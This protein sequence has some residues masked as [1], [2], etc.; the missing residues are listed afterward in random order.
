MI[1][2]GDKKIGKGYPVFIIGEIGL[3][4]NG[5]IKTAKKLID[6]VKEA[7]ADCVKFQK[8]DLASIYQKKVLDDPNKSEQGFQYLIPRLK[9]FEFGMKEYKEIV[10]YCRKKGIIF[11]CTPWDISSVNFL[12]KLNVL[13]Y[14]ISSPD[15]TNLPLLDYVIS[16]RKPILIS[17]GMSTL[18]EIDKSV[19][20]LKKKKAEF[21]LFHCSSTYPAPLEAI[22][23]NFIN[24]L[25]KRY[26]VPVGYSGHERGIGVSIAVVAMGAV[27][28][29]RHITLDRKME[30][31]DHRASLEPE[32]F[33]ALVK[34]IREAEKALGEDKKIMTR[35]EIL[36]REILGKSLVAKRKIKK[37][38]VLK[39]SIIAVKGPAKGLS[40]QRISDLIGKKARRNMEK[41]DL[42]LESDLSKT[43]LSLY[44]KKYKFKRI[45][46]LKSRLTELDK[47]VNFNPKLLELHFSDKD[48]EVPFQKR[49]YD[50]YLYIH[51]P[52]YWQNQMVDLCS[53]NEKQRKISI[54][55]IKK[56]LDRARE[57]APYFKG[58]PRVVIHLGG[59]DLK[60]DEDKD[61][62][63]K[64]AID[65][66]KK[67][68][69]EGLEIL[70][71]NLP[72]RP[73]YFSGQWYQ[74]L[75]ASDNDIIKFCKALNLNMCFDTSHAK[76]YCNLE[77]ESFREYLKKVAPFV[78][79]IHFSD[80]I[81]ID[82]EGLQI[83]EGDI[84]FKSLIRL[85]KDYEWSWL[86]EIWRGHHQNYRGFIIALNK[87]SKYKDL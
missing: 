54:S 76:L 45:W 13:A 59:M 21:L 18:E 28:I 12:E 41:D 40:P 15:L 47:A 63:F 53:K 77:K 46:G 57:L 1:K 78:K 19:N 34:G 75:F 51:A 79:H 48:L 25:K 16:K 50:Q 72:P 62:L 66:F 17:T 70:P 29:E 49:K 87:L 60:I 81:G 5:S 32:E 26:K 39:S 2:I 69:F 24:T 67:L 30:G 44:K 11:L 8:R 22:N 38:E 10:N 35:G 36:T 86:P 58:T 82:G 43:S 42:F 61:G 55:V 9:R 37:G 33:K 84:D 3:N 71:E 65:S 80:T 85:L 73:W 83:G 52:E 56:T 64:N 68:N 23:L 14:K 7:G 74:N 6:V 27:A 20:F 4:H 31:P